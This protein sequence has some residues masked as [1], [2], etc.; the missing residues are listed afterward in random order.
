MRRG[1]VEKEQGGV[2]IRYEEKRREKK[3]EGKRREVNMGTCWD[4]R[5][6]NRRKGGRRKFTEKVR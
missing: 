5:R 2:D 1:G 4:I 3:W 6:D